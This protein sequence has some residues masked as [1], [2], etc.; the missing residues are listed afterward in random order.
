MN[1]QPILGI[2]IGV[3]LLYKRETEIISDLIKTD[4]AIYA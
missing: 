4:L 2:V 1:D 3:G